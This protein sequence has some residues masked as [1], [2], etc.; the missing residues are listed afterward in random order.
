MRIGI[1]ISQLAYRNTGVANYLKNLL[2]AIV[3]Q[4]RDNEYVLFYSSLRRRLDHND[5]PQAPNVT[6]K[7]F[8]FPPVALSFFWNRLHV[9]PIE[10]LVGPLDIFI[11]SDWTE[12]PTKKAKKLTILY[13]LIINRYPEEMAELIVST[14]KRKLAWVKKESSAVLCISDATKRDAQELLGIDTSKLHVIY[15]GFTL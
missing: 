11:T 14:Q 9:F 8:H 13:D 12:P 1:D 15:P 10:Q 3:S 2:K 5:I 6:L 4:D 7:L